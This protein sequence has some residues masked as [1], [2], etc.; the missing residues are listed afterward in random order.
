MRDSLIY[1]KQLLRR[2]RNAVLTLRELEIAGMALIRHSYNAANRYVM[3]KAQE[4]DPNILGLISDFALQVDSVDV[5][6]VYNE[7]NEGIKFSVRSCVREVMANELATYLANE[8]GNG[9]GHID[10]AAGFLSKSRFNELHE[11]LNYD[12]YFLR[13]LTE[14]YQ[15]FEVI[16]VA[17]NPLELTEFKHYKKTPTPRGF[18]KLSE[19][20]PEGT[21]IIIRSLEADIECTVKASDILIIDGQGAISVMNEERFYTN[22]KIIEEYFDLNIEYFPR[23]RKQKSGKVVYLEEYTKK[24]MLKGDNTIHARVLEKPVKVFTV[25]SQDKYKYGQDGD[26]LAISESDRDDV[27]V[28][29]QEIFKKT[30]TEIE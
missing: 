18:V 26:Y 17:K 3:V 12:A 24:C 30:Y 19:V 7:V 29:E 6:I 15:S 14:Y 25:Y 23:I 1:D 16:D 2:L 27:Y 11:Y 13:K 8:L 10:R 5:C 22:Y 21:P 28:I 9:G 20:L 4:C